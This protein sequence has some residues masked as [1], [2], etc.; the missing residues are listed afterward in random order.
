MEAEWKHNAMTRLLNTFLLGICWG[1]LLIAQSRAEESPNASHRPLVDGA[2][3]TIRQTWS[4][5]PNGYDRTALV[6][7][8]P[9]AGP[10]P[11]V[12]MF[13]CHGGSATTFLNSMG[14][15]FD[16]IIRVA[17]NGYHQSWNIDREKSQAPDVDF[18]RRLIALLKTHPNVDSSNL[19]IYGNSNGSGLVNRLL[20][21]L[22]AGTFQKAAGIVSQMISKMYQNGTFR[23]NSS[24]NNEYDEVIVPATGR[25]IINIDGTDDLVIPYQ[26]GHA[27]GTKFLSAQES[28]YRFAQA[29]GETGPML[30]D[31][32]GEPGK[33]TKSSAEIVRYAYLGGDVV[34]Y[35]VL[36]GNHQLSPH[37]QEV[38]DLIADFILKK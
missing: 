22:E 26:G 36:G 18:T 12:I 37:F 17:P 35:K 27:V 23:Y 11:V 33:G 25:K 20:I 13:H 32:Q 38:K 1:P 29:M 16:H 6:R 19:S 15:R 21:E 3:L 8:P 4:Q 2:T 24:G 30:T 10:F 9:G 31:A 28:I 5:E 14:D 34:H 7:V